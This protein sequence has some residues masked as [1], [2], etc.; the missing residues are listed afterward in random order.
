M[1]TTDFTPLRILCFG[2]WVNAQAQLLA[3]QGLEDNPVIGEF[4]LGSDDNDVVL[5]PSM[6]ILVQS[7]SLDP[8][9]LTVKT[10]FTSGFRMLHDVKQQLSVLDAFLRKHKYKPEKGG[11]EDRIFYELLTSIITVNV[12][13][14]VMVLRLSMH[15]FFCVN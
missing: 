12:V 11:R 5:M 10:V 1:H 6:L 15:Y 13:V 7:S 4:G 8:F 14:P 9:T 2:S 3:E